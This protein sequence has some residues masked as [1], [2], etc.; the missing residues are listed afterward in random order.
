MQGKQPRSLSSPYWQSIDLAS[1]SIFFSHDT[2]PVSSKHLPLT[3]KAL[4]D[5]QNRNRTGFC[6]AYTVLSLADRMWISEVIGQPYAMATWE[7]ESVSLSV[8]LLERM[9][10]KS[11]F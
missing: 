1:K 6:Q 4:K 10:A 8:S 3:Q 5:D 11:Y 2:E 7:I 9:N